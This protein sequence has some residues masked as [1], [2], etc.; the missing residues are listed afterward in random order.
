MATVV[1]AAL[2]GAPAGAI[3]L[4]DEHLEIHGFARSEARVHSR[5]FNPAGD[6]YLAQLAQTLN[7]ELELDVAPDGF[8]PFDSIAAFGRVEVRFDCVWADGCGVFDSRKYFGD[9]A[10]HAPTGALTDGFRET[11]TGVVTYRPAIPMHE[12]NHLVPFWETPRYEPL[13]AFGGGNLEGTL[14]PVLDPLPLAAWKRIPGG[15]DEQGFLLAPWNR[16]VRITSLGSL[17]SVENATLGLPLRPAVPLLPPGSDLSK[18]SGLW[19]PHAALRERLDHIDDDGDSFNLR[20]RELRWN[21]GAGQDEKELK[22]LYLEFEMFQG[23]LFLRLGKQSIV[24]GKTE[25]FRSQDQFNPQDFGL[26]TLPSLEESRIALWSARA[27]WSFYDVGSLEDV[28]LE[29]AAVYDDFQP[30][31]PGT[32]GEPYTVFLVCAG[33]NGFFS[34]G[35]SGLGVAGADLPPDPWD[36]L[37]GTEVGAR[38]EWRYGRFSFAITDYWGYSDTPTVHRFTGYERKVDLATGEP[39]DVDGRHFALHQPALLEQQALLRHPQNRQLFDFACSLSR[40]VAGDFIPQLADDCSLTVF[41]NTIPIASFVGRDVAVADA[42]AMVLGGTLLPGAIIL[43]QIAGLGL[44]GP[45]FLGLLVELNQDEND[46][47]VDDPFRAQMLSQLCGLFD[48]CLSDRLTSAQEALLGCGPYYGTNCDVHGIDFFNAEASAIFQWFPNFEPGGP[49]ATRYERG[50]LFILPG[51]RGPAERGYDPNVDGCVEGRPALCAGARKLVD[52][53]TGRPFPSEMAAVSFNLLRLLAAF[54]S[55]NDPGCQFDDPLTCQF[56]RSIFNLTGVGRPELK[57]GGNERFGR[58]DFLWAGGGPVLLEFRKRNVA[59]FAVDFAEDWAKTNW[60][61]EG[62]WFHD[63]TV[64]DEDSPT[65]F[66]EADI[67]NLTLSIDR[68][69]FVN[70]LNQN[71]TIL[72]NT[73]IFLQKISGRGEL[74]V[75]GTFTV[76]T[77]YFNDRLLTQLTLVHD[78]HSSSG[79][80]IADVTWRFSARFS[81]SLGVAGFYGGAEQADVPLFGADFKNNGGCFCGRSSYRGLSLLKDR[82]EVSLTLRYTF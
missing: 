16:E 18:P 66:R 68:P 69:T 46:I 29:L 23:R 33:S 81:A 79:G 47:D 64:Y 6:W 48:A 2:G 40:G 82:D 58:R 12:G 30:V 62:T 67:Y 7:V 31:D 55:T 28:R 21:H 37:H 36:D 38:L 50:K 9:T 44:M 4:F 20:E 63:D 35:F 72:F 43:D 41:Q 74:G 15:F 8:G 49:V 76:F 53:T 32:C 45:E 73:Q 80:V 1:L 26:S 24:W 75:L 17:A 10:S 52:P 25:L 42:F 78:L 19:V 22:E 71:R 11:K 60:S 70:F 65:L 3:D 39:L 27:I 57:A 51:A 34:H 59:G 5:N 54:G 77:G 56:V 13:L 14:G 61:I